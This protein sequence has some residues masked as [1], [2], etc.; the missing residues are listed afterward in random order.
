MA[1][2]VAVTSSSLLD[3]D[4]YFKKPHCFHYQLINLSS[5]TTMSAPQVNLSDYTE[6]NTIKKL[7]SSIEVHIFPRDIIIGIFSALQLVSLLYL[8]SHKFTLLCLKS[9]AAK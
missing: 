3:I 5:A 8:S 6:S 9:K 4:M 1:V 2:T 7:F